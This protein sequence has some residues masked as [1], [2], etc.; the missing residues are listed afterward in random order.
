MNEDFD[1]RPK[2]Q[3]LWNLAIGEEFETLE[4]KSTWTQDECSD[5]QPLPAHVILKMRRWSDGQADRFNAHMV[6]GK[7][8]PVYGDSY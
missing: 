5:S 1:I 7:T 2:Q 4:E 8:F 6:P 3:K